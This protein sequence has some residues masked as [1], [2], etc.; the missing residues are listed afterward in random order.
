VRLIASGLATGDL[1]N[2]HATAGTGLPRL[3]ATGRR[4]SR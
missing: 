3:A 4:G 2:D 1:D